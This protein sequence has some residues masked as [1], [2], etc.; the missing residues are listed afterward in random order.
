MI[1]LPRIISLFLLLSLLCRIVEAKQTFLCSGLPQGAAKAARP[2]RGKDH[3]LVIFATFRETLPEGT[4]APDYARLIFDPNVEGSFSHFYREMSYGSLTIEGAWLPKTYVSK[5]EAKSYSV[6]GYSLFN[7]EI[8]KAADAEIDF[9]LY[10]NDGPDGKPN[11]GDDDGAVDFTFINILGEIPQDFINASASGIASLGLLQGFVTDDTGVRGRIALRDGTTHRIFGFNH[12]VGSMAH[13]YGHALGLPDLYNT[14]FM[15]DPDQRPENDSAGIGAWGLMGYGAQG[16][17]GDDGPNPFSAWERE[18]LGW[19]GRNNDRL[20][21]ETG[22]LSN[23]AIDDN[24]T[25]GS[26]NKLP[27]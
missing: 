2:T 9:S 24:E 19:I 10:D 17:N 1:I 14:S 25:G 6:G 16:W 22:K 3:V 21:T 15:A 23:V 7:W 12:A 8:L 4:P 11:S 26:V 18:Q 27:I 5:Q 13:E 20:L